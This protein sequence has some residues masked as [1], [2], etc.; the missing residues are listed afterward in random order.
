ML[1]AVNNCGCVSDSNVWTSGFANTSLGLCIFVPTNFFCCKEIQETVCKAKQLIR[2]KY[3][4]FANDVSYSI[5]ANKAPEI[6]NHI[7]LIDALCEAL[8]TYQL[9][10]HIVEALT[11]KLKRLIILLNC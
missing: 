7:I 6:E 11:A 1:A 5:V 3:K 4:E 8:E 2:D 9:P 10:A